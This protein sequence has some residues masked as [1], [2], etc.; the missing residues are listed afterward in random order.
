MLSHAAV[1][2]HAVLIPALFCAMRCCLMLC[3][4]VLPQEGVRTALESSL[5]VKHVDLVLQHPGPIYILACTGL[6]TD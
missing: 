2:G 6:L 5:W 3:C 4:A 1:I